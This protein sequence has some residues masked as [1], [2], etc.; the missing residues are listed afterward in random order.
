MLAGRDII[1]GLN[2]WYA[3][4]ATVLLRVSLV[5][6]L[7]A[8]PSFSEGDSVKFVSLCRRLVTN[9]LSNICDYYGKSAKIQRKN[10][11]T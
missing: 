6:N 1:D 4:A 2:D 8:G 9:K 7:A 3:H 10:C 5:G 11:I